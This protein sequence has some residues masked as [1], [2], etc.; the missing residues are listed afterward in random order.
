[1]NEEVHRRQPHD[2]F[3]WKLKSRHN[4]HEELPAAI[5][6]KYI[7]NDDVHE[8]IIPSSVLAAAAEN[9]K[10]DGGICPKQHPSQVFCPSSFPATARWSQTPT[11]TQQQQRRQDGLYQK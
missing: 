2:H 4:K 5:D 8:S 3:G 6:N 10:P 11:T 1:M 7:S 9:A